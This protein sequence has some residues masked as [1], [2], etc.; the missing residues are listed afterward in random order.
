MNN[1]PKH[2]QQW[3]LEELKKSPLLSFREMFSKYSAKFSKTEKTFSKDWKQAQK[4]LQEWQKSINEEVA[5]QVISTEVEE[6]KKGVM[7]KI[8]VLK[9]LSNVVRGKGREIDGEKFFPSY[10]ERISAAAQLAKMEGWEAPIKQEVKGDFNVTEVKIV[11]EG[12]PDE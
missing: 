11:W 9:F 6:R 7:Q 12:A 1:P 2:R 3:I 8:D 4:Q 10:R 5:K